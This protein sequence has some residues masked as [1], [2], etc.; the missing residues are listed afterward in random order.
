MLA[1]GKGNCMHAICVLVDTEYYNCSH[2][3]LLIDADLDACRKA[4]DFNRNLMHII[5]SSSSIAVCLSPESY[6]FYGE[7][8]WPSC[9]CEWNRK[10]E[11]DESKFN[12]P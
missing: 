7:S 5:R 9:A 4:W 12:T 1:I 10:F 8:I 6:A 2:A 11:I 3:G